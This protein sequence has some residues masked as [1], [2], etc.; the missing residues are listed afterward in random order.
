MKIKTRGFAARAFLNKSIAWC[1][2][3]KEKMAGTQDKVIGMHVRI[4]R[5]EPERLLE[6]RDCQFRL[7]RPQQRDVKIEERRLVISVE[8][9]RCLQLYPRIG[10]AALKPAQVS[11]GAARCGVVRISLESLDQQLLCAF[12]IL[13][14]RATHSFRS[15]RPNVRLRTGRPVS[16]Y[17]GSE[18]CTGL[19]GA[20]PHA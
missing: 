10:Q 13:A 19:A 14:T 18:G 7:I 6:E 8:R 5:T 17:A 15:A 2:F 3:T 1:T 16:Q 9:D 11:H 4:M 20:E 12:L